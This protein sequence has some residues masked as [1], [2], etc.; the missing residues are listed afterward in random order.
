[1]LRTFASTNGDYTRTAT[2]V[3]MTP[4]DVRAEISSLLNGKASDGQVAGG[5]ANGAQRVAKPAGSP[6]PA[7]KGAKAPARASASPV[8]AKPKKR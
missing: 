1:V 5:T 4:A 7:G 2:V 6:A 8:R 3:G